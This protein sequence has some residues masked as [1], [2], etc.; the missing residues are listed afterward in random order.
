MRW[1][2][3][4][5]EGFDGFLSRQSFVDAVRI[6]TFCF[7]ISFSQRERERESEREKLVLQYVRCEVKSSFRHVMSC[8]VID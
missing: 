5:V 7:L 1:G 3:P 6:Y 4:V 2:A 8:H